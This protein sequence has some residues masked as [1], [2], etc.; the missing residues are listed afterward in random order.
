MG[1]IAAV[2]L[3]GSPR[4]YGQSPFGNADTGFDPSR[5]GVLIP[6]VSWNTAWQNKS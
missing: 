5:N 6:A 1:R 3:F 2:V 4:F